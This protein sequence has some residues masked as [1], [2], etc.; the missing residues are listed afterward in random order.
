M[1]NRQHDQ[2]QWVPT[3]DPATVDMTTNPYG[4]A[5]GGIYTDDDNS[6]REP[7]QWQL[8]Q[9][10]ST[11]AVTPYPG[12]VMW[13]ADKTRFRVTTSAARRGLYAGV[14]GR[15]RRDG[16]EVPN[17]PGAGHYFFIQKGGR[18]IVKLIDVPTANPGDTGQFVTPSA[19]AGKAD[20]LAAGAA[21]TYPLVG[22]EQ[23][24][25]NVA[26]REVW[27]DLSNSDYED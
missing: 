6:G 10:D 22:R 18:A 17:G 14:V 2:I 4:G 20:C 15:L 26:A 13:W 24:W 16:T 5:L 21:A 8:V 23:G 19:V 3:G 27:V 12:A 11:M 7:G 1:A 25:Y 9:G